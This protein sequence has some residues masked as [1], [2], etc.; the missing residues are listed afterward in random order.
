MNGSRS[1]WLLLLGFAG[2]VL[3]VAGVVAGFT[4][5]ASMSAGVTCGSV[6]SPETL[7]GGSVGNHLIRGWCEDDHAARAWVVWSLIVIGLAAVVS[8]IVR[9]PSAR[10]ERP[11]ET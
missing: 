5:V 10:V 4:P 6:F 3:A 1:T 9:W 7:P 2:M 8:A 11:S